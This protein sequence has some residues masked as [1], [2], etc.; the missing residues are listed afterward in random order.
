MANKVIQ[1]KDGS[2]N[3]YPA[4]AFMRTS[5]VNTT[6]VTTATTL[7]DTGVSFTPTEN[8]VV[9]AFLNY[10]SSAPV[11]I[12][13]ATKNSSNLYQVCGISEKA[14]TGVTVSQLSCQA[15]V[16][17]NVTYY[18]LAKSGSAGSNN[19]GVIIVQK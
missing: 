6:S 10:N 2:D 9:E 15:F 8:C 19:V 1:L 13:V 16:N 12:A 14:N 11:A 17:K 3:L 18:I 7:S 4:A 5:L